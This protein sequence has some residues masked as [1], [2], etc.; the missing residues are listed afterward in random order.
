MTSPHVASSCPA[1]DASDDRRRWTAAVTPAVPCL[2]VELLGVPIRLWAPPDAVDQVLDRLAPLTA[3]ALVRDVEAA[4]DVHVVHAEHG[5]RADLSTG[6]RLHDPDPGALAVAAVTGEVVV[7]SPDLCVHAGVVAS[8]AGAL[9]VPGASGH[10]KTTL[11]AAL[12]QA[13]FGYVSDEVLAVD[14]RTMRVHPFRRPLA[15]AHDVWPLLGLPERDRPVP[16][17]ERHVSPA[18]LG[19]SGSA[20]RV[21]QLVLTERGAGPLSVAP[22]S[23]AAA[24]RSLLTHSFNHYRD[25]KSSFGMAVDLARDAQV[26]VAR[27]R[28][29]TDLA[30]LLAE[31]VR[32]APSV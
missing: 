32:N 19:A 27:Y 4:V 7:R 22:G 30:L 21:T 17:A 31:K 20:E 8:D 26:W 9:A 10:G 13:G 24:V 25:P 5:F 14:R 11:V 3:S 28:D 1:R 23:R 6:A 29:A 15:L 2:Q 18:R 16:G 12:V